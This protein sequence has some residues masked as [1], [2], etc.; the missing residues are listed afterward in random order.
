MQSVKRS[1]LVSYSAEDIYK[2]VVD[3][4]SYPEFLNWCSGSEVLEEE[5]EH[6]I[7]RVDI[8]FKGVKQSFTT[9]NHHYPTTRIDIEFVSGPFSQLMGSWKF[10][11]LDQ[12]AC[13]IELDLN[14]DFSNPIMVRLVGPVFKWI[15]DNQVEAFVRRAQQVYG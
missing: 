6:M 14:F 9:R 11:E 12:Q 5:G 15:A 7:A 10:L 13:K 4:R 1:A 8:D 3:V 2:L